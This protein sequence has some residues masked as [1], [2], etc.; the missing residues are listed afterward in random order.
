M[1]TKDCQLHA[2]HKKCGKKSPNLQKGGK[3]GVV[4]SRLTEWQL[5]V[6]CVHAVEVLVMLV[7]WSAPNRIAV[8]TADL[9]CR[10][11]VLSHLPTLLMTKVQSRCNGVNCTPLH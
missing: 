4:G 7:F 11:W 10:V 1:Y 9:V 3:R 6:M 8:L 2:N 5:Y